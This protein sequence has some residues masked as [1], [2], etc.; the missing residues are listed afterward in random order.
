MR[1]AKFAVLGFD[2]FFVLNTLLE[3]EMEVE[4]SASQLR[5]YLVSTNFFAMLSVYW[6][7]GGKKQ[8]INKY[9]SMMYVCQSLCWGCSIEAQGDEK[10]INKYVSTMD[11]GAQKYL[12]DY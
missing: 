6:G 3:P 9:V 11:K 2:D 1:K 4:L 10:K 8:K 12:L 7:S 5:A